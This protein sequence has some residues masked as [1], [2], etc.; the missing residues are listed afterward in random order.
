MTTLNWSATTAIKCYKVLDITL[1][2]V[3]V[4]LKRN[5]TLLATRKM[6]VILL[7]SQKENEKK[8]DCYSWYHDDVASNH[9]WMQRQVYGTH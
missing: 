9:V 3:I 6:S 8:D 7:M 4:M 2:N 5:L 1:G